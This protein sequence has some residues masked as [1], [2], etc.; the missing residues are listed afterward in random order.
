MSSICLIFLVYAH[1]QPLRIVM[2]FHGFL[3]GSCLPF[4]I[5]L[6]REI[7]QQSII[8]PDSNGW[9]IVCAQI[10][11]AVDYL[12]NKVHIIHNDIKDDNILIGKLSSTVPDQS[13][14]FSINFQIVL[15]DFGKAT[16]ASQGKKYHL[17]FT[18][19]AHYHRKYP[20]IAPEVIEGE[21][22]QSSS[23][24]MFSVGGILYKIVDNGCLSEQ[25]KKLTHLAEQCRLIRYHQ[26]F[27]AQK[28]L[29][30]IQEIL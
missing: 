21:S 28:A 7:K 13:E 20:H 12:H 26:R 11:E 10:L 24:D 14:S 8:G 5:T 22:R 4:S 27:S 15:I 9:L 16:N 19:R 25:R 23:S 3:D 29:S 6:C 30:F 17:S 2:Q 1:K 18:E